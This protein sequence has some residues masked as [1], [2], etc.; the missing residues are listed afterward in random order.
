M[1]NL[2]S[3]SLN[4]ACFDVDYLCVIHR[5]YLCASPRKC[6]DGIGGASGRRTYSTVD[7][8]NEKWPQ[9]FC[10]KIGRVT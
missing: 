6:W 10:L 2:L 1:A 9:I 5:K 3:L 8:F 4:A 7:P